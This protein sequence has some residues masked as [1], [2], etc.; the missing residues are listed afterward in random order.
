MSIPPLQPPEEA[1]AIPSTVGI[2]PEDIEAPESEPYLISFKH[3]N[4]KECEL[5]DTGA[6]NVYSL[7]ALKALKSMGVLYNKEYLHHPLP[8]EANHPHIY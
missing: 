8:A 1:G 4:E 3:Y 6:M 2:L 5:S 7:S